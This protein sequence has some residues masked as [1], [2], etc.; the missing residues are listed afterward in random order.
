M[1]WRLEGHVFPDEIAI[2]ILSPKNETSFGILECLNYYYVL[3]AVILFNIIS[4]LW[5]GYR[6]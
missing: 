5:L 1:T 6:R 3:R 4:H 2:Q